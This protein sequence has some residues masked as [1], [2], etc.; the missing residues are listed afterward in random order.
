MRS[1]TYPIPIN[2][3]NQLKRAEGFAVIYNVN[4]HKMYQPILEG[5][6]NEIDDLSLVLLFADGVIKDEE[7]TPVHFQRGLVREG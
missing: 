5:M 3:I 7:I 1:I 4:G 2:I 6:E